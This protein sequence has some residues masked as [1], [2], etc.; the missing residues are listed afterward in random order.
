MDDYDEL[1]HDVDEDDEQQQKTQDST[2]SSFDDLASINLNESLINDDILNPRSDSIFKESPPIW[3][4]K[5]RKSMFCYTERNSLITTF[6]LLIILGTI[7]GLVTPPSDD[8]SKGYRYYSNCIGYTY[9]LAWSISFYP[10]IFLNYFRKTTIG[11]EPF[12]KD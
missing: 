10:Q 3:L 9:F 11:L 5:M 1:H 2:D 4:V 6:I 8:L 7:L 12:L